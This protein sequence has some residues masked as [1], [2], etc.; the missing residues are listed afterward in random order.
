M[1]WD[2]LL[3]KKLKP[4][5]LP[6]IKAPKDVSNFDEEF[7]RLKPV[8]TLPRTTCILTAEQKEIFADF[9]FS[10][11][12]WPKGFTFCAAASETGSSHFTCFWHT[13]LPIQQNWDDTLT[14]SHIRPNL[15]GQFTA[16]QIIFSLSAILT[17]DTLLGLMSSY[18]ILF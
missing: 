17:F 6:V 3:A 1:D 9:D 10:L 11:I 4:P 15:C 14:I 7:T 13:S 12:S 2:A 5:F 8:L 16:A 18:C